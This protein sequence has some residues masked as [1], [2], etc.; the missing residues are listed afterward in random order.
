MT[1]AVTIATIA[2]EDLIATTVAV[3]VTATAI[4]TVTV[5]HAKSA[6]Q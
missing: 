3:D 1:V 5:H 2:V 6:S 4:A